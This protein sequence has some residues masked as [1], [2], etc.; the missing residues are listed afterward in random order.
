[1]YVDDHKQFVIT[2]LEEEVLDIA[3][4]DVYILVKRGRVGGGDARRNLPIFWEPI[5]DWYRSPF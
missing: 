5:G 4:K 1:M 2:G 3:E